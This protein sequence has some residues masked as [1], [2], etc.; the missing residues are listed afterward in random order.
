MIAPAM[1]L[2]LSCS[3]DH[4]PWAM[5]QETCLFEHGPTNMSP[6]ANSS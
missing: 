2:V 4:A 6:G 5:P 1:L 3:N